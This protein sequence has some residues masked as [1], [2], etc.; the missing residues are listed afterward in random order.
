MSLEIEELS[1][2]NQDGASAQEFNGYLQKAIN[3]K[4]WWHVVDYAGILSYHFPSSP[5]AQDAAF[6]IGEAYLHLNRPFQ[7]NVYFSAYLNTQASP[8]RFEEAI[9]HKFQIAERFANGEK[10]P[11]FNDHGPKWL[12]AKEDAIE[13]YD[14]V[15]S[16]LPHSEFAAKSLL[17][18]AKIQAELEDYKPSLETLD[19]LIRR[20]PKHELAAAAYLEKIHVFYLQCQG[21]SLDP[22]LLD[23]AQVCLKKF[24]T[25]FPREARIQEAE[26]TIHKMEEA[27]AQNLLTTGSF[28]QKTRKIPAAK[29]YYR[30]AIAKYPNTEAANEAKEKLEKLDDSI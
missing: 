18:K 13:I 28:F 11:L 19:L 20:F 15:I 26:E 30:K 25:V 29:I 24:R 21:R 17:G 14:Q 23:L 6:I 12:S 10:K 2:E 1:W 8:R 9:T 4:N 27:F 5:F 3:D 16:T 7:A 22:D